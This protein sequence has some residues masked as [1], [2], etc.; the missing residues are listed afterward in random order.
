MLPRVLCHLAA[1]LDGRTDWIDPDL[2]LY[3]A[4]P[5]EWGADCMLTGADT[6]LAAPGYVPDEQPEVGAL[7]SLADFETQA[8][9]PAAQAGAGTAPRDGSA[10]AA[11]TARGGPRLVIVDSGGRVRN[12]RYLQAQPFWREPTALCS[13][14]TPP[15]YLACL[16]ERRV[17][18]IVTGDERVDLRAALER[19][20]DEHGVRRV[21]V[22]S[23][24]SL[25]SLL[26]RQGLVDEVSVMI[27]PVLVG[28]CSPRW[29]YRGPDLAGPEGA[30]RLALTD[31]RRVGDGVV[32]LR[33]DVVAPASQRA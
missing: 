33:Y 20:A 2:G 6:I 8:P 32:W 14:R 16:A 18:T 27:E 25:H 7:A 9:P 15:E 19:L 10:P 30:V 23:G 21:H 17:P 26:L 1:S 24:G 29:W 22:D 3:Y 31:V 5:G 28:G 4:V 11:A 12:W 13:C